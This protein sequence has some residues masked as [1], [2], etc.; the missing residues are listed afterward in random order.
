MAKPEL[1]RRIEQRAVLERILE[2]LEVEPDPVREDRV[3]ASILETD[4]RIESLKR[5]QAQTLERARAEL[6]RL[7]REAQEADRG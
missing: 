2:S 6:A 4:L 5:G 3:R 1:R 7:E